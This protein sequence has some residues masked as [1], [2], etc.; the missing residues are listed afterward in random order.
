MCPGYAIVAGQDEWR[1]R[2]THS[3][4]AQDRT[5]FLDRTKF[6]RDEGAMKFG[7]RQAYSDSA[8]LA[9]GS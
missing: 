3:D 2:P 5:T 9:T 4:D 1:R 7:S 8:C 6:L